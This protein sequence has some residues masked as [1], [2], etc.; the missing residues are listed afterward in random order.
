MSPKSNGL[1]DTKTESKP[2]G[3][4]RRITDLG[5]AL[6][7]RWITICRNVSADYWEKDVMSGVRLCQ[8][9]MKKQGP[10]HK[11]A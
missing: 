9:L 10:R 1:L 4:A 3:S 7:A 8:E 6:L 2:P 11:N 5:K